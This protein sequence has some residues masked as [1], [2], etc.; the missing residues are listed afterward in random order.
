MDS[1]MCI[2]LD[3]LALKEQLREIAGHV[4]RHSRCKSAESDVAGVFGRECS[5]ISVARVAKWQ[6]RQT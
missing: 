1:P 3:S 6:T 5:K 2:K 4:N